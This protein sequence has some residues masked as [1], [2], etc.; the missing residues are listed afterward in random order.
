MTQYQVGGSLPPNAPTY[1]RR[2]ASNNILNICGVIKICRGI[3]RYGKLLIVHV[4]SA[5]GL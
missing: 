3:G 4:I 5:E 2:Q 1:V